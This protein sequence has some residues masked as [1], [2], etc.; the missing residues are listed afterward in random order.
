MVQCERFSGPV[1]NPPQFAEVAGSSTAWLRLKSL[2]ASR[3]HVA[4]GSYLP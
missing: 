1:T 4:L 3:R 2:I